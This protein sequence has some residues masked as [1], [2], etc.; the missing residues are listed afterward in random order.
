[1]R[2]RLIFGLLCLVVVTG[3]VWIAPD[4]VAAGSCGPGNH[5]FQTEIVDATRTRAGTIR[6]VCQRCGYTYKE[7][8]P[9]AGHH[10]VI[11]EKQNGKTV[12]VC[13]KCGQIREEDAGSC[14]LNRADG[15]FAV[16]EALL[17]AVM[18][19]LLV[20][21]RRLLAWDRRQL[22]AY[23]RHHIKWREHK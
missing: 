2:K 4:A 20:R 16:L 11:R 15:V 14:R 8:I 12:F 9:P 13:T 1:M 6:Y 18:V 21:D 7:E 23:Y 3:I 10:F 19:P 5:V 17:L 22:L